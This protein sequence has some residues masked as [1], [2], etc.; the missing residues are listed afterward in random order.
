MSVHLFTTDDPKRLNRCPDNVP[1]DD[2]ETFF[3]LSQDDLARVASLRGDHNRLGFALQLCCLRYLGFFPNNL[4]ELSLHITQHVA[5]QLGIEPA[6]LKSYGQREKTLNAHQQLALAHLSY[7]RASPIDVLNL[8]QW[9]LE[10]AL[11]H[12]KPKLLF[13]SACAYLHHQRII[14]I[15]TTRLAKMVGAARGEAEQVTFKCLRPLLIKECRTF[16]DSLLSSRET[17]RTALSWLQRTP[18]SNKAGAILQTLDKIVFLYE[19]GVAGWE[20]N[21]LNPN[22]L[23]V[24]AKKGSRFS[25]QGLRELKEQARYPILV[26]FLHE[27]LYTFTDALVEMVDQ[28]LW[29]LHGEA[30]RTFQ[31]DRLAAT[32]TINETLEVFRV[33]GEVFLDPKVTGSNLRETAYQYLNQEQLEIALT[34][35]AYLIR[36]DHDAYVDYF[37][38]RYRAVQNFSKRLLCTMQFHASSFDQGL[39][40][41]LGL[42]RDIHDGKRRKLPTDAPTAFIPD[43]WWNEVI[44]EE[45]VNWRSYELAA[46]WVLRQKLR[47]GDIYV[48][49]S[50]R[51]TELES[52]LIPK[53]EWPSQRGDVVSILGIPLSAEI[54]LGERLE[55]LKLLAARVET[56]LG[57]QTSDLR[58]ENGKLVLTPLAIETSSPAL[59]QLRRL[60]DERLPRCD[61]TDVLIEVDNWTGFSDTLIHQGGVRRRDRGLLTQ[62]FACLLAQACNLGFSQMAISAELSYRQLLW[63]NRWYLRDSTLQEA[64]TV[65]V[66]YHHRLPFSDVWGGGLLSSSD[67]QRFPV[68]GDTRRGRALPR[69]FGYGKGVTSYTWSSDQFSQYGAKVIPSTIRD[70]TYVLDAILDNETD[71]DIVEH[72]TDTA[73]YTELI[74]A[75]FGL[76]GLTFSPRIRDLADQQ[77]YRPPDF[78][79]SALP[80]LRPHLSNTLDVER[81]TYH[82]EEMLRSALSLKK[83]YG[84]SSLLV[85]KLQAYPRQHPLTKAL[86]EVGR[87]DKTIHILRWYEDIATRQRVSKQLNKGEALHRLRAHLFYGK[88]G[89]VKGQE[90]EPLDQQ[91]ACLNLVTNAVIIFNTVHIAKVVDEL[92][93]DGFQIDES[94]LERIWP[95]RFRHINLFGRYFFDTN[96]IRPGETF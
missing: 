18:T 88:L 90:D 28:R 46:L 68:K 81:I 94:D 77:L 14:R 25:P 9:L 78:D 76:L 44:R 32:K 60:I 49:H 12:D 64:L 51:F 67:G 20:L 53:A 45:G 61:I 10:R 50:R 80:R 91:L 96:K 37:A 4:L 1:G 58:E 93:C 59:K 56:L 89:E 41:G 16:L 7:R 43:A 82:W 84:T 55:T 54:R 75:L 17:G 95:T 62:L 40:E 52:Y 23:K 36:P 74:F 83:G 42:I 69:Y 79:M 19:H 72:T 47:S 26:A 13:E 21:A 85:Q 24:L 27:A 5:G 2:L 8:E 35:A 71:L 73:G 6:A 39:L 22:R 31:N 92:R 11:E 38:K 65:L 66:N 57:D 30:K 70:A 63:C 86:Q 87:L 3:Q 33:I 48:Q 15:G 34:K 29:E